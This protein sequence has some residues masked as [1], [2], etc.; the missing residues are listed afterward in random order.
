MNLLESQ[1]R[2]WRPRRPSPKLKRRLF[3]STAADDTAFSLRWLVP[4]AACLL[5][6]LTIVNQGPA[7]SANA[8]HR[9]PTM[10]LISSNVNYTNLLPE[11]SRPAGRNG[12]S[13]ASF[14]WT[15][16]SGITSS[17]SPFTPGRMN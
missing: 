13:P 4:A 6:A 14:E 16:L 7:L 1:L 15:N 17:I 2:S 10:G 5:L 11:E 9:P 8:S 3:P 12:I